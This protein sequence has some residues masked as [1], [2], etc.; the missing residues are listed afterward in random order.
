MLGR[1]ILQKSDI[2]PFCS[3]EEFAIGAIAKRFSA[4]DEMAGA[5]PD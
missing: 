2:P 4:S 1:V 5:L 3:S